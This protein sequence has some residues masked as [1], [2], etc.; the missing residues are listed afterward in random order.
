[1]DGRLVSLDDAVVPADDSAFAEGRGCYSALRI[2][3]G[4]PRFLERHQQRLARGAEALGLGRLDPDQVARAVETLA[5]AAFPDGE[6]IVRLQLSRDAGGTL[7][8]VGVPRGLGDEPAAWRAIVAPLR[9]DGGLALPGGHKLSNRLAQALALDAAAEAGAQEALLLDA[10][11]R[12][13]E[14]ARSNV[15]VVLPDGSPATPPLARGAV[16]GIGRRLVLERVDAI[17]ERDVSEAE[18]RA[19]REIVA[20]N[21]VRGA[22]PLVRLDGRPVA[23]GAP[24]PW[25]RRLAAALDAD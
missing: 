14:G 7:H 19:A 13:V 23:D 11:G 8:L 1:M 16:D 2:R 5:R 25:A 18:L 10:A 17:A 21:A 3:G 4:K 22:V 15:L 9:H 12:L 20:V 6:G 24:G